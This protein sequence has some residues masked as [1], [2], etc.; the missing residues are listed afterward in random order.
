M[1][2]HN[3]SSA[4]SRAPFFLLGTGLSL[5]L[6]AVV[7]A[8]QVGAQASPL[9]AQPAGSFRPDRIPLPDIERVSLADSFAAFEQGQAVFLDV[10]F[11]ENY[12]EG[13]VPGA[14]LIPETELLDRLG[15]LDPD[16]WIITYCT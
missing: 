5:I 15:E 6:V 2:K 11:Q 8:L 12:D 13:H 16:Q 7:W 14:V 4:R 1:A 3:Q 9:A 10:R